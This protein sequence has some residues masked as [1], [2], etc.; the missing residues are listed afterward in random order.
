M[1]LLQTIEID[2]QAL[3]AEAEAALEAVYA[4]TLKPLFTTIA[5]QLLADAQTLITDVINI[6]IKAGANATAGLPVGKVLTAALNV[7]EAI[8]N[9]AITQ[10]KPEIVSALASLQIAALVPSTNPSSAP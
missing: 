8:E 4:G 3:P 6:F 2:I 10:L 9:H 5:P 7:G 1:G